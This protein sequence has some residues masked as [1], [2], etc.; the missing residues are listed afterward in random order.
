MRH[1][2]KSVCIE[3][4]EM[5]GMSAN[6]VLTLQNYVVKNIVFKLNTSFQ[7]RGDEIELHP[8]FRRIIHK[9][10]ADTAAIDL[11][12]KIDGASDVPFMMDICIE[13][14]FSMPDWDK[15]ES[16]DLMISNTAAILFPY[17]RALITMITTNANI[18]PYTLPVMNINELF[19]KAET[20]NI[21]K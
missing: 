7:A 5:N 8:E 18:P 12:F 3:T 21:M 14:V 11:I 20:S 4:E 1:E 2:E 6:S 17:L 13:G 16:R 10:D 19:A 9:I 15:A